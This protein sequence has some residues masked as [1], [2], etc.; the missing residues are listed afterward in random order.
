MAVDF[1][2]SQFATGYAHPAYAQFLSEFGRFY[3][4]PGCVAGVLKREISGTSENDPKEVSGSLRLTF[5]H[6]QN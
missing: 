2:I 6:L 4:L 5:F 1:S 3:L